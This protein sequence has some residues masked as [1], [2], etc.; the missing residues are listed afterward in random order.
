MTDWMLSVRR[1]RKDQEQSTARSDATLGLLQLN[2]QMNRR[3]GLCLK[4]LRTLALLDK[5]AK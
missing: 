1:G 2:R 3:F 4:E 5:E